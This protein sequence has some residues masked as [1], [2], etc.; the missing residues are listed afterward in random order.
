[1]NAE[2]GEIIVK[3]QRDFRHIRLTDVRVGRKSVWISTI[4]RPDYTGCE[5]IPFKE[6]GWTQGDRS[7]I[8]AEEA[9]Q[10]A[11]F[12]KTHMKRDEAIKNHQKAVT[13][14]VRFLMTQDKALFA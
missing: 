9:P 10:I 5:T 11:K 2:Q 4:W 14:T 12:K 6:E 3:S 7:D 1:M 13:A 8:T